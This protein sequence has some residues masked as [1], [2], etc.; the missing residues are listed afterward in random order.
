MNILVVELTNRQ[1]YELGGRYGWPM[2][3]RVKSIAC[4]LVLTAEPREERRHPIW[5]HEMEVL[6][7]SVIITIDPTAEHVCSTDEPCRLD[8]WICILADSLAGLPIEVDIEDKPVLADALGRQLAVYRG[9]LPS[10]MQR[11]TM[12]TRFAEAINVEPTWFPD[13]EPPHDEWD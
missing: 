4:G 6:R 3:E 8:D 5:K 2:Y 10:P 11:I 1:A 7:W 9:C 13:V 12:L